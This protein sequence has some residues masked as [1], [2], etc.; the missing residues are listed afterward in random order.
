MRIICLKDFFRR[1]PIFILL[2]FL[3]IC[4]VSFLMDK[5]VL[6]CPINMYIYK[7]IYDRTSKWFQYKKAHFNYAL[8]HNQNVPYTIRSCQKKT[9]LSCL[10][11]EI[12]FISLHICNPFLCFLSFV[13]SIRF[14][15]SNCTFI[16]RLSSLSIEASR[17]SS[18]DTRSLIQKNFCVIGHFLQKLVTFCKEY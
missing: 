12:I 14:S 7:S 9:D 17:C 5:M 13:C 10:S 15:L 2:S 3:N 11:V 6:C 4:L 1:A 8:T 16:A 18:I